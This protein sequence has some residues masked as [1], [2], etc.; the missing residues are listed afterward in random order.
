MSEATVATEG[1]VVGAK[2][3]PESPLQRLQR[4]TARADVARKEGRFPSR[5]DRPLQRR[6]RDFRREWGYSKRRKMPM[7]TGP[8]RPP[9]HP[10]MSAEERKRLSRQR[11]YQRDK[12]RGFTSLHIRA[13]S[14]VVETFKARAKSEKKSLRTLLE[15]LL[16]VP[17]TPAA[18][19]VHEARPS[20][21]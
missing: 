12:E 6:P 18:P 20:N 5:P 1:P 3:W 8:G 19:L 11:E 9:E 4:L 17:K 7:G 21:S 14:G 13:T 10:E 16:G 15:E 2:V